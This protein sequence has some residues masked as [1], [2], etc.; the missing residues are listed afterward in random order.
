M[1]AMIN[2]KTSGEGLLG[3]QL[4]SPVMACYQKKHTDILADKFSMFS[5]GWTWQGFCRDLDPSWFE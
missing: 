1:S 2:T 3:I 5:V 4:G